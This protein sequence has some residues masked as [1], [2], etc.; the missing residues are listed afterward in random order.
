MFTLNE[1][2]WKEHSLHCSEGLGCCCFV[3][4]FVPTL[5]SLTVLLPLLYH[6]AGDGVWV[7]TSGCLENC[8][9]G[10]SGCGSSHSTEVPLLTSISHQQRQDLQRI[11]GQVSQALHTRSFCGVETLLHPGCWKRA[12]LYAWISKTSS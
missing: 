12:I 4:D 9:E 10:S 11:R 8:A 7:W 2:G 5:K 1:T 6:Q 3:G